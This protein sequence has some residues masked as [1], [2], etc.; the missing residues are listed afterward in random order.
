M[1]AEAMYNI[2][3]MLTMQDLDGGVYHK[4]T[5]PDFESFIRPDECKKPRY[6]VM[7]TTAAALDFAATMALAA[8]VYAPYE[9]TYL[10]FVSEA[11]EA[12]KRAYAWA[13]EHPEVYYNQP[14]MNEK[15]K[16]ES[17]MPK[18]CTTIRFRHF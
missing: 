11:T 10:G 3:W 16:P 5:E 17:K 6:V 4:L 2:R 1:L 14:A 13:V 15:F 12:A 9:R 7:K 8:R 18:T